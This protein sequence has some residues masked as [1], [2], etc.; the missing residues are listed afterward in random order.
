LSSRIEIKTEL[1]CLSRYTTGEIT[2]LPIDLKRTDS[3]VNSLANERLTTAKKAFAQGD[4]AYENEAKGLCGDIRTLIERI[5]EMDLLNEVLRRFSPEVN[6][7]GKIYSLSKITPEDCKFIDDYMTKYSR[8][9]HSQP[10][11]A[12]VALPG[13]DE[14]ATD[15]E[16]ISC[17]I[18]SIRKRNGKSV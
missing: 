6:T 16:E 17:F 13:P 14:I 4:T 11:E 10:E 8:Y 3:A 1:S 18:K 7:K 9:E 15:L 12:P 5:V 2:E